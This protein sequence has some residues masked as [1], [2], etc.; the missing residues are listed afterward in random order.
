MSCNNKI[1]QTCGTTNYSTCTIYEG[2]TNS[3]SDLVDETCLDQE[4]VD[5]DQYDQLEKIWDEIDLTE[6]GNSCLEYV[7]NEEGKIIVKNVL[8]K[9][10]EKICELEEKITALESTDICTKDITGCGLDFGD[11]VDSC[12]N[13]PQTLT[14]VL[15][16]LLNQHITP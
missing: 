14:D 5:Q 12:G 1:K 15:Q 16:I 11:L 7:E 8:L 9:F 13:P 4:L 2:T 10:E 6:L 3:Q